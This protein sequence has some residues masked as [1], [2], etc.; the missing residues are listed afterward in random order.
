[1]QDFKQKGDN[2][3]IG[4]VSFSKETIKIKF[5][6]GFELIAEKNNDKFNPN[7]IQIIKTSLSMIGLSSS[8]PPKDI[9]LNT[10]FHN[11]YEYSKMLTLGDQEKI[12]KITEF[13]AKLETQDTII[14]KDY[15]LLFYIFLESTLEVK[16]TELLKT[17]LPSNEELGIKSQD[18]LYQKVN[19]LIR[20]LQSNTEIA[21]QLNKIQDEIDNRD[22][23][24]SNIIDVKD[25]QGKIY[26]SF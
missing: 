4:A 14:K 9:D 23:L 2:I 20:D 22:E 5:D 15:E 17:F 10:V 3:T 16:Q 19:D 8:T 24:L 6:E 12:Q 18:E 25:G 11:D 26:R 7:N 13:K 1:M 21:D